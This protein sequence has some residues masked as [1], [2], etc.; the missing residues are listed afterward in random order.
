MR[1]RSVPPLDLG[2]LRRGDQERTEQ[3]QGEFRQTGRCGRTRMRV[4][5]D[6]TGGYT[7]QHLVLFPPFPLLSHH[8]SGAM[9]ACTAQGARMFRR[10][11]IQRHRIATVSGIEGYQGQNG[12]EMDCEKRGDEHKRRTAVHSSIARTGR[13]IK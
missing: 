13:G 11:I 7:K 2:E 3:A 5:Q 8:V 10:V 12:R 1:M 9:I 6:A 4:D